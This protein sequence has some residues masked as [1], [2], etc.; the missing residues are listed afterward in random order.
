MH[1]VNWCQAN[2]CRNNAKA[3]QTYC[4][5]CARKHRPAGKVPAPMPAKKQSPKKAPAKPRPSSK[6]NRLVS[7][8]GA[9]PYLTSGIWAYTP[10]PLIP[11]EYLDSLVK[12]RLVNDQA[13]ERLTAEINRR[14]KLVKDIMPRTDPRSLDL[15]R[16]IQTSMPEHHELALT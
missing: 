15:L 3:G 12:G 9:H 1:A 5:L 13:C 11:G 14:R 8:K 7:S 16:L 4:R 6:R 2:G 10:L